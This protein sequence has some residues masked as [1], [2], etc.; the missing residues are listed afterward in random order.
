MQEAPCKRKSNQV[1]SKTKPRV[2]MKKKEILTFIRLAKSGRISCEKAAHIIKTKTK[3]EKQR[4]KEK[5]TI[6]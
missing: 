4:L 1:N 3:Y 6:K 5:L 2:K